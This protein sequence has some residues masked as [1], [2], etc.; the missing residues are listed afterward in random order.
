MT[1]N[2]AMNIELTQKFNMLSPGDKLLCAVS[3]GADSMCLLHLMKEN[4]EK[5]G[6]TVMA[7]H[8]NHRLRGSEALRDEAFVKDYCV[9]NGIPCV[10]GSGDVRAYAEENKLST[11]E[12]A[13]ILRYEFLERTAE[14]NGCTRIATAHNADDNA[15]TVLLNL[16]RGSGTKGLCGIPPVRGAFIRP[17][18]DKSRKEIEKYLLENNIPHVEDSTNAQDEYSRNKIRHYVMPVLN[19]LNPSFSEAVMRTSR[20][21]SEDEEALSKMAESFI[22]AELKDGALPAAGLRKLPKAVLSRVFRI[23]CGRSLSY[24]HAV[25]LYGLLEGEGLS[26]ADIHGMRVSR[27]NGYIYFGVSTEKLP[28]LEIR[29][30]E[31]VSADGISVSAEIKNA[32]SEVFNSVNTFCFKS[33]SVCGK[34]FLTPRKDGDKIRLSRRNCTKTLKALFSEKKMTQAQRNM[35]AVIRDEKGV[36]AVQGFGV[37]ER[38]AFSEGDRIIRVTINYED[39]DKISGVKKK[40]G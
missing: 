25:S 20:L 2:T 34:M 32:D 37:C 16:T 33:D 23:M 12:A 9:K 40:N 13:R 27:D 35:T 17:I 15:E 18:L 39:K 24:A 30:G 21:M 7:A 28:E 29:P 10:S 6:I 38:C 31:S 1:T 4:A 26:Y 19:E 11:E 22:D 3:G 5:L 14:E 8:F 36:I